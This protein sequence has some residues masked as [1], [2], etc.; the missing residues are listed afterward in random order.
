MGECSFGKLGNMPCL[1]RKSAA[2]IEKRRP[3][4]RDILDIPYSNEVAIEATHVSGLS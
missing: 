4:F 1:I 2:A 3:P